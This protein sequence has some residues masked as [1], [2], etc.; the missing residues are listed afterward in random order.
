MCYG[1]VDLKKK[2]AKTLLQIHEPDYRVKVAL[3]ERYQRCR[4]VFSLLPAQ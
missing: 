3:T 1:V 4:I 2:A